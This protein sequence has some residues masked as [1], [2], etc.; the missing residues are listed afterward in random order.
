MNGR[1]A[2][3]LRKIASGMAKEKETSYQYILTNPLKPVE[4]TTKYIDMLEFDTDE[5]Q[6][7]MFNSVL[8]MAERRMSTRVLD[9][10]CARALYRFLKGRSHGI[11]V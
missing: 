1:K 4:Y 2:K 5:Q 11:T 6:T 10:K 3:I 9:N 8:A 7:D